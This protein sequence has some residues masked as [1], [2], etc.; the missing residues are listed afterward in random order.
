[1]PLGD[2][3][4]SPPGASSTVNSPSF[5]LARFDGAILPVVAAG[6]PV[7]EDH[8]GWGLP[9]AAV[10]LSDLQRAGLPVTGAW[11]VLESA[12]H[13]MLVAV[14]PGWH[15][16]SGLSSVDLARKVGDTVFSTKTGFGIPKILLV[17]DDFDFT[18]VGQG[19]WAFASR[20]HPKHGEVTFEGLAQNNLPVFLDPNEKFTYH[21]AKV[22]HSC[23]L[24]DRYAPSDRPV[25]A[26]LAHGWPSELRE[27]VLARW[28]DYG[29]R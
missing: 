26:D 27:R 17:E 6:P 5:L 16:R 28:N 22:V 2:G 11:M 19:V 1:M 14:S 10:C 12:C 20:A 29:Y 23:L 3:S 15:E 8:T 21:A 7:E 18:D 4:G 24:A 25:A 9:H 13:W